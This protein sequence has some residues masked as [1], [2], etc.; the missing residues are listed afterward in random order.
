M[1]LR[2]ICRYCVQVG[3]DEFNTK[4]RTYE[5]EVDDMRF[6]DPIEIQSLKDDLIGVEVVL[7]EK[8]KTENA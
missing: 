7:D 8:E 5:V 1:K 4:W 6:S 2:L 3:P